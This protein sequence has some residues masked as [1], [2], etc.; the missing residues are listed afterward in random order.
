MEWVL[1]G[2]ITLLLTGAL[3]ILFQIKKIKE[4]DTEETYSMM[5]EFVNRMEKE[6]DELYD[7][8]VAYIQ[9]KETKHNEKIQSL[10]SKLNSYEVSPKEKEP[11]NNDHKTEITQMYKQGFS[12][13]QI[14]KLLQVEQGKVELIINVYKKSKAIKWLNVRINR[15]IHPSRLVY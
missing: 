7:K 1:F 13:N 8:M 9:S 6:N 3:V 12:T 2:L 10:E 14:A 4:Q 15:Y 11:S 5:N